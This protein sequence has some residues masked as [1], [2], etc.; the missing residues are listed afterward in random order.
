M[1]LYKIDENINDVLN[2]S[3]KLTATDNKETDDFKHMI[4]LVTIDYTNYFKASI[5]LQSRYDFS[6][7]AIYSC[8]S[9]VNNEPNKINAYKEL[10]RFLVEIK[11]RAGIY[12]QII[13]EK[14][15]LYV[16]E[17]A[18]VKTKKMKRLI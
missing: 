17:K 10:S 8:L 5:Y 15:T 13:Q 14:N 9:K 6:L 16:R 2:F 12:M 1:L 4:N 11:N 18:K 7:Q 3:E